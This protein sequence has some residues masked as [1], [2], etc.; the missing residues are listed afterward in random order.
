MCTRNVL[1]IVLAIGMVLAMTGAA[2]AATNM[3]HRWSFDEAAGATTWADDIGTSDILLVD[4]AG[5]GTSGGG[6][7]HEAGFDPGDGTIQARLYGGDRGNADWLRV[8]GSA[9]AEIISNGGSGTLEMWATNHSVRNWSRIFSLGSENNDVLLHS[10]TRGTNF[11]SDRL[12]WNDGANFTHD[13]TMHP[14]TLGQEFHMA[15]TF[16][17]TGGNTVIKWYKDGAYVNTHTTSQNLI[18]LNYDGGQQSALGRSK[19]NDNT[20]DA[21]WNEFR[22]YD[23]VLTDLEVTASYTK[24]TS[25]DDGTLTSVANGAWHLEATWD[26][27]VGPPT[28]PTADSIVI[29]DGET[30]FIEAFFPGFAQTLTITSGGVELDDLFFGGDN[31]TVS[32]DTVLAGGSLTIGDGRLFTSNTSNT[33]GMAFLGPNAVVDVNIL[34]IDSALDTANFTEMFSNKTIIIDGAAG[35][36]LALDAAYAGG[37]GSLNIGGALTGVKDFT[38]GELILSQAANLALGAGDAVAATTVT[39]SGTGDLTL[40][41]T[42]GATVAVGTLDAGGTGT[43]TITGATTIGAGQPIEALVLNGATLLVDDGLTT[44]SGWNFNGGTIHA[45]TELNGDFDI[46]INA[47]ADNATALTIDGTNNAAAPKVIVLQGA[48]RDLP[49]TTAHLIELASGSDAAPAAFEVSAT[50]TITL[51]TAVNEVNVTNRGSFASSAGIGVN[52]DITLAGAG[53]TDPMVWGNIPNGIRLGSRSGTGSTTLLNDINLENAHRTFYTYASNADPNYFTKLGGTLTN[54]N[55]F[56]KRGDGILEVESLTTNVATVEVFDGTLRITDTLDVGGSLAGPDYGRARDLYAWDNG[57]VVI[58]PAATATAHRIDPRN[59]GMID[60]YGFA[61]TYLN[62]EHVRI[63]N[64]G[65]MIIR[66]GGELQVGYNPGN[67][68]QWNERGIEVYDNNARLT[69]ESNGLAQ[70]RWINARNGG[71]IDVYGTARATHVDFNL[72]SSG[73]LIIR[74]G[75]IGRSGGIGG[76]NDWRNSHFDSNSEVLIEHGGWF[77]C[78]NGYVRSNAKMDVYGEYYTD[79]YAQIEAANTVVTIY[80]GGV[81]TAG[82]GN[83]FNRDGYR[84]YDGLLDIQPGGEVHARWMEVRRN[85]TLL[86][87]GELTLR[88]DLRN[89]ETGATIMGEGQINARDVYVRGSHKIAPGNSIGTLNFTTTGGNGFRIETNG[90]YEWELTSATPGDYDVIAVTGNANLLAWTLEIVDVSA[91]IISESDTFDIITFTGSG[92]LGTPTIDAGALAS[93]LLWDFANAQLTLEANSIRLSG[94]SHDPAAAAASYTWDDDADPDEMWGTAANWTDDTVPTSLDEAILN[95]AVDVNVEAN[96]AAHTVN[97]GGSAV[98][99]KAGNTLGITNDL[100]ITAGSLTIENTAT[101]DQVNLMDL[102][103]GSLTV[104]GELSAKKIELGSTATVQNGGE[105]IASIDVILS[106]TVGLETG[107]TLTAPVVGI[108]AGTT[109]V[110]NGVTVNGDLTVDGGTLA[111]TGNVAMPSLTFNA[112]SFD[113]DLSHTLTLDTYTQTG[114][115]STLLPGEAIV[116]DEY[117]IKGGTVGF[118]MTDASPST[119]TFQGNSTLGAGLSHTYTGVTTASGG[120]VEV[121]SEITQTA[122]LD[123]LGGSVVNLNADVTTTHTGLRDVLSSGGMIH[124]GFHENNDGQVCDLNNNGGMMVVPERPSHQGTTILTTGPGGRGIDFTNDGD[125]INSGVIGQNDNYSNLFL[126]QFRAPETG[127]YGWRFWDRDDP[128][129]IWIDLDQDGVFESSTPGLGANRGEQLEWN[130]HR[131]E[132]NVDLV[133]GEMYMIAFTHREGGGGSQ[134]E[135]QFKTPTIDWRTVRPADGA[136]AGLWWYPLSDVSATTVGSGGTLNINNLATLTTDAV[137]LGGT[138]SINPGGILDT[139]AVKIVAGGLLNANSTDA[140]TD[141]GARE[142]SVI[143]EEDGRLNFGAAQTNSS[144]ILVKTFATLQGDFNGLVFDDAGG[145]GKVRFEDNALVAPTAGPIPLL[146]EVG[147]TAK[148]LVGLLNSTHSIA[149]GEA[150]ESV[151]DTAIKGVYIG[152]AY[153]GGDYSGTLTSGTIDNAP[154]GPGPEDTPT[155]IYILQNRNMSYRNAT[156]DSASGEATV[157][158]MSGNVDTRSNSISNGGTPIRVQFDF[159]PDGSLQNSQ[160]L[161]F[162]DDNSVPVGTTIAFTNVRSRPHNDN[163]IRGTIEAGDGGT[164]RL[165]NNMRD[166]G[167]GA[168]NIVD[169]GALLINNKDRLNANGFAASRITFTGTTLMMDHTNNYAYRYDDGDHA[170]DVMLKSNY[171]HVD[172]HAMQGTQGMMIGDGKYLVAGWDRDWDLHGN[173]S[174]FSAQPGATWVGIAGVNGRWYTFHEPFDGMRADLG[175]VTEADLYIGTDDPT[176]V[177]TV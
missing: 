138:M 132:R 45:D 108:T 146:S 84:V 28:V 121:N 30:V 142:V 141:G 114:G 66:D 61:Y 98:T 137:Y 100:N 51:G 79:N 140:L 97:I 128:C 2:N 42:A 93:D 67:P 94:I 13:N 11:N 22:I 23:T 147:G 160:I 85:G 92:S 77:G 59:G 164:L 81:Q 119:V 112:G 167:T 34:T 110:A 9:F 88:E 168:I 37:T 111:I 44:G 120:T 171:M 52:A 43:V 36:S 101:I 12:Q 155:D 5:S 116:A 134:I 103:G 53:I 49:S 173:S 148:L 123:V 162:H 135:P 20:A 1:T 24:G 71:T 3:V 175:G 129:G 47:P 90:V 169:G 6:Q 177:F 118:A 145:S 124:K 172:N 99:V 152:S 117:I 115:T 10:W 126:G 65:Q 62:R 16:E 165:D 176:A 91:G 87:N 78:Q 83:G 48:L 131:Q 158:V 136:Q 17:V 105:L 106:G 133:A 64:G 76:A 21:S 29:V 15:W 143:V 153:A 125:F 159:N 70:F 156:F 33:N 57:T 107:A 80:N 74:D 151:G 7:G 68:G 109:T 75:G 69:I 50:G 149:A 55:R 96:A 166:N 41:I 39:T 95:M 127:T 26:G 154:P 157:E 89:E 170:A 4:L 46:V 144:E 161:N 86:A 63:H 38:V 58:G 18:N 32:K 130:G 25:I 163:A 122:S 60:I 73:K 8:Q 56:D 40:D 27:T 72:H 102:S 174:W 150:I 104:A 35:G 19:W 82:G 139:A 31:L 54:V 113:F 14:F